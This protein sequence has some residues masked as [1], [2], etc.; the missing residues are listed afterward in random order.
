M[1]KL[2][3]PV[4]TRFMLVLPKREILVSLRLSAKSLSTFAVIMLAS[5]SSWSLAAK[6][7]AHVLGPE[8]PDID[9]TVKGELVARWRDIMDRNREVLDIWRAS[10]FFLRVNGVDIT[11]AEIAA[12]EARIAHIETLRSAGE[13]R[14][15]N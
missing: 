8:S 2:L 12:L 6:L 10:D 11:R 15:G 3:T 14:S 13:A 4:K 1:T 7:L 9:E 5:T